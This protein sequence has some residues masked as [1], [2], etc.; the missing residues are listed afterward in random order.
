[1]SS[2][3]DTLPPG[4][5]RRH[6]LSRE[7]ETRYSSGGRWEH[8][9]FRDAGERRREGFARRDGL[10][11]GYRVIVSGMNPGTAENTVFELFRSYGFVISVKMGRDAETKEYVGAAEVVY[12]HES[13]AD[14]ATEELNGSTL[15]GFTLHV[16]R[17]G[18]SF[19]SAP[20]RR[21]SRRDRDRDFRHDR[22]RY[23][24]PVSRDR[25]PERRDRKSA[26]TA[27]SLDAAL[28]EYM[29]TE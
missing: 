10:R 21:D 13:D 1:M 2:F 7:R 12:S 14:A 18:K 5:V 8:D 17:R 11:T 29:S 4:P 20:P 25:Q 19:S 26:P 24:G 27:A 22:R 28:Q 16:E 15:N 3:D 23:D 9:K 6:P